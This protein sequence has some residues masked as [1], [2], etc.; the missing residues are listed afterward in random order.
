ITH[1][2][3]NTNKI[4]LLPNFTP[5]KQKLRTKILTFSPPHPKRQNQPKPPQNIEITAFY[6]I[7]PT[8]KCTFRPR[9]RQNF[10]KNTPLFTSITPTFPYL[11]TPAISTK[12]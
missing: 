2:F 7:S 5:T 8:I 4:A 1:S 9:E 6:R 3:F 12:P 11:L 10:S